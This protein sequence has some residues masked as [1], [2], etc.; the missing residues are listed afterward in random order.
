MGDPLGSPRAEWPEA[1]NILIRDRGGCY[2]RSYGHE[3][4]RTNLGSTVKLDM[5]DGPD[6]KKYFSKFY[7]CFQGIKQG[8]TEGCRRIIGLDGCFLKGVCKG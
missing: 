7:C 4:L 1:D 6:G 2:I 3:I 8:W 5:E